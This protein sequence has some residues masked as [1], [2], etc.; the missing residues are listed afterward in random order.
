METQYILEELTRNKKVFKSLFENASQQLY[1]WKPAPGKWCLL[2]ILCHLHD[3]EREDF[4]A[5]VQHTLENPEQ[6]MT[7][8]DP[9]GW[10]LQRKYI[11]QDYQTAL[12]KFLAERDKSVGWLASLRDAKWDNVYNHPQLGKLSASMFLSAWLAHDYL[13]IRQISNTKYLY[14]KD[15]TGNDLSYAGKW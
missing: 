13:H 5:R 15:L 7:P 9:V 4:R 14:L 2:E 11:E 1:L 3:E 8:I 6:P 10:V 12:E